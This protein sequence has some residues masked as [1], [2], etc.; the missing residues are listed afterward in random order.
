MSIWPRASVSY[1][2]SEG[3]ELVL[4]RNVTMSCI[5]CCACWMKGANRFLWR[6]LNSGC[7][8]ALGLRELWSLSEQTLS[9][10]WDLK[11]T[12]KNVWRVEEWQ[13]GCR[14]TNVVNTHCVP[15]TLVQI[16]TI[17]G[18]FGAHSK[19]KVLYI[20]ISFN[21]CNNLMKLTPLFSHFFRKGNSVNNSPRP[22][23]SEVISAGLNPG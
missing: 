17:I 16:I 23:N 10:A 19:C 1:I 21:P 3:G 9:K 6:E 15:D 11:C 20:I 14:G 13:G 8:E 5:I 22:H 4:E 2:L 12:Q 7:C 18:M